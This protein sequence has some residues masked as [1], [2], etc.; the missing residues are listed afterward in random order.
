MKKKNLQTQKQNAHDLR[1][2]FIST[3]S[4][5]IEDLEDGVI[6]PKKI[7]EKWIN[8]DEDLIT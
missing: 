1:K 3:F 5:C 7:W 4:G 8:L 2:K 6:S